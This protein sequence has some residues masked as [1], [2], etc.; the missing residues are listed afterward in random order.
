MLYIA[1]I[2]LTTGL[3]TSPEEEH[4]EPGVVNMS[5][6]IVQCS[7][8]L[9]CIWLAFLEMGFTYGIIMSPAV[10]Y[11]VYQRAVNQAPRDK[12]GTK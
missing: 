5:I 9:T 8:L 1:I 4:D 2:R 12:A 3:V 7:T 6:S 10:N 11:T